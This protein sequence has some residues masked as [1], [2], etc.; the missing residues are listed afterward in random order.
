MWGYGT[1]FNLSFLVILDDTVLNI[2]CPHHLTDLISKLGERVKDCS[3]LQ[4]FF[5][6]S[7]EETYLMTDKWVD[8]VGQ[9]QLSPMSS[10]VISSS[11]SEYFFLVNE[12][13]WIWFQLCY[14][15]SIDED[16]FDKIWA[17]GSYMP[18]TLALVTFGYGIKFGWLLLNA[19]SF[20]S[21]FNTPT[22]GIRFG[23]WHLS[24]K[25]IWVFVWPLKV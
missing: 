14:K 12:F 3:L 23:R 16:D 19:L 2:H 21:L 22:I 17:V 4:S 9:M 20:G 8:D 24:L 10:P 15:Y 5:S 1:T 13:V 25:S 11:M 18:I 7:C 6:V